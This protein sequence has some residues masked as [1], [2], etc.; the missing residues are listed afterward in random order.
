[1]KHYPIYKVGDLVDLHWAVKEPNKG[2]AIIIDGE[3][4]D[5]DEDKKEIKYY[6]LLWPN[7]DVNITHRANILPVK[8]E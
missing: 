8:G 3:Y 4:E 6:T 7:G 2:L 5:A 1:M